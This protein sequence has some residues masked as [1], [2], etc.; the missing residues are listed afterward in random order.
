MWQLTVALLDVQALASLRL[1][2]RGDARGTMLGEVLAVNTSTSTRLGEAKE[3]KTPGDN[4][5]W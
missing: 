1:R 5:P 4:R 2:K 3:A